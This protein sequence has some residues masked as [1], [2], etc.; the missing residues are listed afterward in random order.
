MNND[1]RIIKKGGYQGTK[2]P[3]QPPAASYR[4]QIVPAAAPAPAAAKP[5]GS[6]PASPAEGDSGSGNRS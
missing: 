2:D 3:G 4:P 5:T 6:T 1:P